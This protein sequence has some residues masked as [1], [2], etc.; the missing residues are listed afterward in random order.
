MVIRSVKSDFEVE[1]L[2]AVVHFERGP[3]AH[4]SECVSTPHSL[5]ASIATLPVYKLNLSFSSGGS[6]YPGR[7]ELQVSPESDRVL[8]ATS[9]SAHESQIRKFEVSLGNRIYP[10]ELPPTTQKGAPVGVSDGG[11]MNSELVK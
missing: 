8:V 6:R 11:R 4:P 2:D 1:S 10:A 7:F 5:D 9:E 3:A